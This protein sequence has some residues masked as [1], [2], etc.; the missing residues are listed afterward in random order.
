MLCGR[1]AVC[2]PTD[3]L[4]N[5]RICV[6]LGGNGKDSGTAPA[7]SAVWTGR[8]ERFNL[9]RLE[10]WSISQ[11][12]AEVKGN[13]TQAAKRLGLSRRTLHRRI[14]AAGEE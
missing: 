1:L 6:A 13:V 5:G 7:S 10:D 2:W 11:A 9:H 3:T 4:G 8:E 14:K 12:L